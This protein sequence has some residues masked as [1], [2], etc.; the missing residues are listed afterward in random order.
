MRFYCELIKVYIERQTKSLFKRST[1]GSAAHCRMISMP[2]DLR[3]IIFIA[4]EP[5]K[6]FVN[7]DVGEN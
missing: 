7:A 2:L 3:E 4:Y 6:Q 5:H 1:R